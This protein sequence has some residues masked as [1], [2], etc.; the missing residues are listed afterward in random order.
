M[1]LNAPVAFVRRI[2]VDAQG[3]IVLLADGIY[4]GDLVRMDMKLK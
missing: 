3:I 1:P 4:R 2:A